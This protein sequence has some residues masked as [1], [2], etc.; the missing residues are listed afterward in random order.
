[1]ALHIFLIVTFN[2][3]ELINTICAYL[4]P[5]TQY[6]N[7]FRRIIDAANAIL[8]IRELFVICMGLNSTVE[9]HLFD[10]QMAFNPA[11]CEND[12]SKKGLDY[13]IPASSTHQ[14]R[15]SWTAFVRR[16]YHLKTTDEHKCS[17]A[18]RPKR[19]S[20]V[21]GEEKCS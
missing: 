9:I 4:T 15:R 2:S 3:V 10:R 19:A 21:V 12:T 8:F 17:E 20:F 11:N 7:A 13:V 5:S 14:L 16:N 18:V 1:M 6:C